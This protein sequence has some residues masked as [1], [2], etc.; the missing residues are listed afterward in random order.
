MRRIVLATAVL[1][2]AAPIAL[3]ACGGSDEP[4]T[5]ELRQAFISQL[6][7]DAASDGAPEEEVDCVVNGLDQFTDEELFGAEEGTANDE[8]MAAIGELYE[9]C[10]SE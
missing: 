4:E 9:K 6:R 5:S 1:M 10:T 7:L 3:A 2:L 8:V